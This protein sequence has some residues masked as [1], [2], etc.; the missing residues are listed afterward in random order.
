MK[1]SVLAAVSLLALAAGAAQAQ[2]VTLYGLVD[3]GVERLDNVGAGE[4][5]VYRMPTIA[6][7]FAS[8]WGMRG[9]EDLGGGLKAIFTLESGFAADSGAFQQG[10]RIFGRQLFVGLQGGWGSITMAASTRC[11]CEARSR[12]I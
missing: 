2:N 7:S 8:R 6:G 11:C 9:S 12:A 5:D 3:T 1:R 4:H 10:G